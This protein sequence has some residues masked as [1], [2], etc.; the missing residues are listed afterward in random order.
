MISKTAEPSPADI[1]VQQRTALI[2]KELGSK[3]L[4]I[5]TAG[6][7]AG[8]AVRGVTGGYNLAR[9]NMTTPPSMGGPRI[10]GVPVEDDQEKLAGERPGFWEGGEATQLSGH[11]LFWPASIATAAGGAYGGWKL[12]DWVMDKRRRQ[13]LN[14][15]LDSTKKDYEKALLE[16]YHKAASEL[17]KDLDHL[18]ELTEKQADFSDYI[19]DSLKPS[20]DTKGQFA[21]SYLMAALP[22]AVASGLV[23]HSLT[24]RRNPAAIMQKAINRRK[25]EL[26]EQSPTQIFAVPTHRGEAVPTEEEIES[27]QYSKV[28]TLGR[29]AALAVK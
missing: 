26:Q 14:S 19:P 11:P 25:Q 29:L 9:R 24:S 12:M 18:F 2:N 22:L 27:E 23:T 7:G 28:A 15:Q 6:A 1:L 17:G 16:T 20:G 5:L 3:L 13:D 4:A 10:I 21:G 8:A